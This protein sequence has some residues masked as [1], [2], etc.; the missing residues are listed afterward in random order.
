MVLRRCQGQPAP[1]R[2]VLAL[3]RAH[4]LRS[5]VSNR[6]PGTLDFGPPTEFLSKLEASRAMQD[7]RRQEGPKPEPLQT[8]NS[9]PHAS[10]GFSERECRNHCEAGRRPRAWPPQQHWSSK[11]RSLEWKFP[12][13][14]KAGI[15]LGN[16]KQERRP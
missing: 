8:L 13:L 1:K 15:G 4:E 16:P 9:R 11:R 10:P 7:L 2:L 6:K 5:V 12:L 14:A 3:W